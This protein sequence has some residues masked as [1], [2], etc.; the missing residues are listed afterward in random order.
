[1]STAIF[2]PF[3]ASYI[4]ERP[5]FSSRDS[6]GE[7]DPN[8]TGRVTALFETNEWETYL[9]KTFLSFYDF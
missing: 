8:G 2:L 9:E 3:R 6:R 7:R 1:M 4:E 5:L